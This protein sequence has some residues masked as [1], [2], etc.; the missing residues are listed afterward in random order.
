[1]QAV[2]HSSHWRIFEVLLP[3]GFA[4]GNDH[5]YPEPVGT[6][7]QC[8]GGRKCDHL[9]WCKISFLNEVFLI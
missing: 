8:R 4:G 3:G 1:M 6:A 2:C 7:L 9:L 5:L